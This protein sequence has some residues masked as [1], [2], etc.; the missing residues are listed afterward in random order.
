MT[1]AGDVTSGGTLF[2]VASPLGNPAD[3]SPRAVSTL[4]GADVVFAE[5]TRTARRLLESHGIQPAL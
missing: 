2:V 1:A 4:G 3:I 5:D